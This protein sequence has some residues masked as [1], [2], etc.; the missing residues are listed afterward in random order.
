MKSMTASTNFTNQ[1]IRNLK[2]TIDELPKFHGLA[3]C[4]LFVNNHDLNYINFANHKFIS[5]ISKCKNGDK[6]YKST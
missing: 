3:S 4:S 5:Y 1:N 2:L 6:E